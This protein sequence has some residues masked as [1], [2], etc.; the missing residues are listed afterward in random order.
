MNL[1]GRL[2]CEELRR[3]VF[4]RVQWT[5]DVAF[6]ADGQCAFLARGHFRPQEIDAAEIEEITRRGRLAGADWLVIGGEFLEQ[7]PELVAATAPIL[8]AHLPAVS[9]AAY[10]RSGRLLYAV[11]DFRATD[12]RSG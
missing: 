6:W 1:T 2:L 12:E 5:P 10:D 8:R 3:E 9:R 4:V 7:H 11:Y